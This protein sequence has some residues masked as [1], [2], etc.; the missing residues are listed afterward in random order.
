MFTI[1]YRVHRLEQTN[2]TVIPRYFAV[3]FR[4]FTTSRVFVIC[5]RHY[6][7]G[8]MKKSKLIA[9]CEHIKFSLKYIEILIIIGIS[10]SKNNKTSA[11]ITIQEIHHHHQSSFTATSDVV[12][13]SSSFH[14]KSYEVQYSINAWTC[15]NVILYCISLDI[16]YKR[17]AY[18][19]HRIAASLSPL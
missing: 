8:L 3:R 9:K 16:F 10:R 18:R 4:V 12:C 1:A 7:A 14:I 17:N 5:I 15:S 11:F 6:F 2:T 19:S 13:P